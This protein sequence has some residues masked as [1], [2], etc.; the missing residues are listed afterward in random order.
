MRNNNEY[1]IGA[2]IR[3]IWRIEKGEEDGGNL[4]FDLRQAVDSYI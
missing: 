4:N 2:K 1:G 3:L